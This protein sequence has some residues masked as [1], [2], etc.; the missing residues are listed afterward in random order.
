M[1]PTCMSLFSHRLPARLWCLSL[2]VWMAFGPT[3]SPAQQRFLR[4]MVADAKGLTN[5][6]RIP[7]Y[8][9]GGAAVLAPTSLLDAE[10]LEEVQEGYGGVWGTYLDAT[11]ELGAPRMAIPATG[12]FAVSLLTHDTRFQDAAFT[13][14]EAWLYAGAV[15]G[16]LKFLFGRFRPETGADA[17]HFAPFSGNASFPSGHT[18]AVFALITPWLYYYPHTATYGLMVLATGTATARI[19]RNKHWPTDVLA[20]AAVGYRMGRYLSRRHLRRQGGRSRLAV[21]PV[22]GTAAVGFRMHLRL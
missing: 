16:G 19:A 17:H 10:V 3:P 11:N 2:F 6:G 22:M 18:T 5:Q 13:S 20:G 9:L 12:L 15:S 1:T 7:L 8:A 21:A 14:F 4:W